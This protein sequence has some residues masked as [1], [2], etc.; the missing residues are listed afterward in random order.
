MGLKQ[1]LV[2]RPLRFQPR[3]IRQRLD[4]SGYLRWLGVLEGG[5][6]C[7]RARMGLPPTLDN[8]NDDDTYAASVRY[9]GADA[10]R[11]RRM[12]D[13]GEVD[14]PTATF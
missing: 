8:E 12:I 2:V 1:D 13:C 6:P 14:A 11:Y 9:G 10:V 5:E 3:R 4:D 7:G